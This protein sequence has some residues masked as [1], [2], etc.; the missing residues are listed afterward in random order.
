M[1]Y[2]A[3]NSFM[4]QAG[5][6]VADLAYL[7]R[8]GAPSTMPFWGAGLQPALPQGY[9][10]DFVNTDVLLNRMS[11]SPDGRIVLAD[12]MSYRVLVLP[13]IDRMT[14]AVARKIRDLVA[15]G[16]TVLGPRPMA[17]PSLAGYPDADRE[18]K[19]IGDEVWGDANCITLTQHAYGKG[20]G[21]CGKPAADVL[22]ALGVA[23][24]F[25]AS[26]PLD[27][28]LVWM[29]R[30][31]ADADIYYV[32]NQ[33]DRRMDLQ[34]RFRVKGKAPEL[35]H[36]DTGA[37]E[38]ADYSDD[39]SVVPLELGERESVFVVFRKGVSAPSRH[40]PRA[41]RTTLMTLERP[42]DVT[43]SPHLGAPAATKIATLESW[44]AHADPGIKYFSGTA[45]YRQTITAPPE[46]FRTAASLILDLGA[47]KDLSEVSLNGKPLGIR[48][49]PPYQYDVTGV[50]R[51]G[52]NQLEI[53]ITNE[54]TNRLLGD[55][56]GPPEKRVFPGPPVAGGRSGGFGFGPQQP[57][58][59]G[60]I[61]PVS[62][63]SVR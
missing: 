1:Q 17:S 48:W 14:P 7:L 43:F 25:D 22:A 36:A 45:T 58:E 18:V 31:S 9:D 60:L 46:W 6:P 52:A 38:A 23:K 42:W 32:A 56:L 39:G 20:R 28:K 27:G 8:E 30:A 41:A 47:V 11:A 13:E 24:D 61:G 2:L 15:G 55:R 44:S 63:V 33:T 4:L 50:L 29:H 37:I 49:K 62:L 21:Y 3:R 51:R 54:W 57:L 10:Y 59:S 53:K 16:A 19:A 34:A 35:W 40:T 5:R 26:L 12:G